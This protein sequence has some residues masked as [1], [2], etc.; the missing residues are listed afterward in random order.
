[1]QGLFSKMGVRQGD[2][3]VQKVYL[4]RLWWKRKSVF[5]QGGVHEIL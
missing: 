5:D 2:E 4:R 1:M 3:G